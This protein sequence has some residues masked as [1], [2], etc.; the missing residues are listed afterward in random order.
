MHQSTSTLLISVWVSLLFTVCLANVSNPLTKPGVIYTIGYSNTTNNF[1][2]SVVNHMTG[3]L[4]TVMT[5]FT[6]PGYVCESMT[7]IET[8]GMIYALITNPNSCYQLLSFDAS[9]GTEKTMK[10][11]PQEPY[12][13]GYLLYDNW[14]GGNGILYAVFEGSAEA[15]YLVFGKI[16]PTSGQFSQISNISIDSSTITSAQYSYESN[17]IYYSLINEFD[18]TTLYSFSVAHSSAKN[19][20]TSVPNYLFVTTLYINGTDLIGIWIDYQDNAYIGILAF[21]NKH[22]KIYED[23]LAVNSNAFLCASLDRFNNNL[24]ISIQSDY[25][26]DY[27]YYFATID[28]ENGILKNLVYTGQNSASPFTVLNQSF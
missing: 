26:P 21:S 15:N 17:A 5:L 25:M 28:G 23:K 4:T 20:T 24:Y 10:I 16:N 6:G 9:T 2:L 19:I 8:Q 12:S 7:N 22:A 13:S 3:E 18:E 27:P 1:D 11:T 14:D